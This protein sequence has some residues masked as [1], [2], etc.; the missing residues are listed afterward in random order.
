MQVLTC[1]LV[2]SAVLAQDIATHGVYTEPNTGMRFY[3]SSQTKISTPGQLLDGTSWGG[4]VEGVILPPSAGTTD[5]SEFIGLIVS[6]FMPLLDITDHSDWFN[7]FN[8]KSRL[9][10]CPSGH[11]GFRGKHVGWNGQ[12]SYGY[13]LSQWKWKPDSRIFEILSVSICRSS[14][15]P[16]LKLTHDSEPL[17]TLLHMKVQPGSPRSTR[18]STQHI[19]L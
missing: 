15:C 1:Q 4:F 13:C 8:C 10:R 7:S 2:L 19:T 11:R 6:T 18:M 3:T 17:R 12:A 9:G 14:W 16:K 5:A